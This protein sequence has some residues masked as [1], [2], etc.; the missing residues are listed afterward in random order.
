MAARETRAETA[1]EAERV[2]TR[3]L[4]RVDEHRTPRTEVAVSRLVD[5]WLEVIDIEK[6]TRAGYVGKTEKHIRP[7]IGRY[8]SVGSPRRP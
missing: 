2:L 4:N 7:T 3:L 1:A 6:K 8:R 5:R